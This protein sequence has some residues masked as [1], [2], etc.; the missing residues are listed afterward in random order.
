VLY[1]VSYANLILYSTVLLSDSTEKEDAISGDDPK[2]RED[3]RKSMF[4]LDE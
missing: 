3:V 1:Q 4:D 2:N